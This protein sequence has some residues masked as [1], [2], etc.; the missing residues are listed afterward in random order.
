M[1]GMYLSLIDSADDKS[2]FEELY[3]LYYQDM[4]KTAD[5]VLHNIHDAEDAVQKSF[6]KIAKGFSRITVMN[7][8]EMKGYIF[9]IAQNTAID[10]YRVKLK[11]PVES[12]DD[13]IDLEDDI[14]IDDSAFLN[15]DVEKIKECVRKLPEEYYSVLLLDQ[16][17]FNAH[18]IAQSLDI[19]YDNAR[20]RV[21]RAK[22]KLKALTDKELIFNG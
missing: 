1:L 18:E 2:K 16:L 13:Y 8:I 14:L 10:I 21:Q 5:N 15:I 6:L 7:S 3:N 22:T 9:T 11:H 20:K 4:L 17:G 19:S 12:I